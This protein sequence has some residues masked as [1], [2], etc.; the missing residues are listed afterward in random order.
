M[1]RVTEKNVTKLKINDNE[2]G[3]EL[4]RRRIRGKT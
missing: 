3:T 1:R 4:I 2:G